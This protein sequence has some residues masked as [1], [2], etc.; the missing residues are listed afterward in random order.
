VRVRRS[1]V[2]RWGRE[3][4]QRGGASW[5]GH[6]MAMAAEVVRVGCS[7]FWVARSLPIA[8]VAGVEKARSASGGCRCVETSLP[9]VAG[10]G[11]ANGF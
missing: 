7:L 5:R 3:R 6:G 11:G 4:V 9:R 10:R 2:K 1:G 8:V